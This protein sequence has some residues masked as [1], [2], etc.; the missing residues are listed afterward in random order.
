VSIR[1]L[2][3][4]LRGSCEKIQLTGEISFSRC[5]GDGIIRA[6]KIGG[7]GMIP[8]RYPAFREETPATWNKT[9]WI[10][11]DWPSGLTE[12]DSPAGNKEST[13]SFWQANFSGPWT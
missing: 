11:R 8:N 7:T 3:L 6:A 13:A 9:M 2:P 5:P 4:S 12:V 1:K 10:H